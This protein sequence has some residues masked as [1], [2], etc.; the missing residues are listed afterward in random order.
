MA[1]APGEASNMASVYLRGDRWWCRLKDE[2]GKWISRPTE[3]AA[4]D[5]RKAL[6]DRGAEKARRA[7][8]GRRRG[9]DRPA[10]RTLLLSRVAQGAARARCAL[11][12]QGGEPDP[13]SLVAAPRLDAPR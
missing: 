5:K 10:H 8:G 3:F 4:S 13:A 6:R 1:G 12:G 2:A 7:P 11:G 9:R